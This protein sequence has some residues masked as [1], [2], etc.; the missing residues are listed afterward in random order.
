MSIGLDY[1]SGPSIDALKAARIDGNPVTF[2]CRYVGYFSGYNLNE[3]ATPQGK[4]LTPGEAR[5]NSLAGIATVSNFE[6][7]AGRSIESA[8]SGEWD[9]HTANTI[10]LG[11]GGPPTRP[12]Y[13]SVDADVQGAQTANYFKGVASVLGLARTGAYGSYKVLQYLFDQRLIAWG[14]Q[15]YAWSGGAWEPRAHIQQYLNGQQLSGHS[16]DYNRSMRN[17]FGQWIQGEAATPMQTYT[18]QSADFGN[19]FTVPDADH[20]LCKQTN[21]IMQLGIKGFVSQLSMDGQSLPIIGLPVT[22][23]IYLPKINGKQ[24]VIQI[25]E[26]AGVGYDSDHVIDRQPGTGDFFLFHLTDANF[27]AHVPGLTLPTSPVD[28]TTL[29][30]TLNAMADG[31]AKDLALAMIEAK[32]L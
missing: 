16:V 6:W 10:H 23:E 4:V 24:V 8:A 19:Y 3:I 32:K 17:D 9:A 30:A 7:Y 28:T 5:A 11:C 21:C 25:F 27:L 1:V 31:F 26:R 18:P 15:T 20:W 14:W 12:I 22:N 29:I 13:F 2:V